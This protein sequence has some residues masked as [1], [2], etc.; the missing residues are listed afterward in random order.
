MQDHIPFEKISIRRIQSADRLRHR[1]H[2]VH[3]PRHRRRT[4][5][6]SPWSSAALRSGIP[7]CFAAPASYEGAVGGR[8]IISCA[9]RRAHGV[10]MQ[11][12][13]IPLS[14]NLKNMQAVFARSSPVLVADPFGGYSRQS[15]RGRVSSWVPHGCPPAELPGHHVDFESV[16]WSASASLSPTNCATITAI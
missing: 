10:I 3:N 16:G 8:K 11:H 4:A 12:G 14:W 7:M 9:Q 1:P 13:S 6:A 2:P 15:A 5:A